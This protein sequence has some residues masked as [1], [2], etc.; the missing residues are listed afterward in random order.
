MSDVPG[1]GSGTACEDVRL[2]VYVR[3]MLGLMD[4]VYHDDNR[5]MKMTVSHCETSFSMLRPGRHHDPGRLS[6]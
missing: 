3:L 1:V 6:S 5:A 4:M 2:A